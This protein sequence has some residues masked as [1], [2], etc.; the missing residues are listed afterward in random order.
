MQR[1][2]EFPYFI[3]QTIYI[4]KA[5]YNKYPD[6]KN[7]KFF[8]KNNTKIKICEHVVEGFIIDKDGVHVAEDGHDGWT[9]LTTYNYLP[10]GDDCI[11]FETM[12]KAIE[13][14]KF[15]GY[16]ENENINCGW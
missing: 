10:N 13:F 12:E 8:S 16:V 5:G 14:V 11:F 3:G 6:D 9:L 2:F 4:I 1:T 15:L 7:S